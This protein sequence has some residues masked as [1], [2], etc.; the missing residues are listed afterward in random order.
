MTIL[1]LYEFGISHN[2]EHYEIQVDDGSNFDYAKYE[3]LEEE[4]IEIDE[5]NEIIKI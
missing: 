4:Q 3:T 5:E 1:D 2:V